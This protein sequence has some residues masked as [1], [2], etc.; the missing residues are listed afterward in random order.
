V[1]QIIASFDATQDGDLMLCEDFGVAYQ[2]DMKAQRVEYSNAYMEK[3]RAYEGS[4]IARTVNAGRVAMLVRQLGPNVR[5]VRVI[6]V[7]AGT[8][9]FIRSAIAEGFLAM[10]YDV[11]P[12]AR[13]SLCEAGL[14]CSEVTWFD[15]VTMWDTIEHM[16]SPGELLARIPHGARLFV[17]LP[18][19]DDLRCVRDSRHYRPG[20]HLY[21]WTAPGFVG[22]MER[23][24]FICKEASDHE[25]RA[26]RDSIGAF[27]FRKVL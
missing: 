23:Y 5:G 17:S 22:W 27:A 7:G 14:W 20:E 2:A 8:G 21:Y 12:A 1:D 18:I 15:A 26:G 11:I 16:E 10:G 24:G 4:E 19:F 3:V 25:T 13:K 6:D 9:E